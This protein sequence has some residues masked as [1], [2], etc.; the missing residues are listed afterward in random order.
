LED[1]LHYRIIGNTAQVLEISLEPDKTLI[2]D[3]GMLLY[4]DEE[5]TFVTRQD[6][7]TQELSANDSAESESDLDFDTPENDLEALDD[8]NFA[9]LQP[10]KVE[11]EEPQG[12]LLEKLWQ[13]TK[14][15][16]QE[17]GKKTG[18]KKAEDKV[19]EPLTAHSFGGIFDEPEGDFLPTE[20]EKE[21]EVFSWY[22]TH[23]TNESEYIRKIAFTT[24]N[25]G[26]VVPIDLSELAVPQ[27]IFQSGTF[28]CARKGTKLEKHLDTGLAVNFTKGKLFKLDR[29][30]G[31]GIVFIQAEGQ[32]IQRELENDA[33]RVSLFSLLAFEEG[34]ILDT[35]HIRTTD[36]MD[37]EDQTQFVLL[38]GTGKFWLQTANI[39]QLVYRLSPIIFDSG[40]SQASSSADMPLE[41]G[42]PSSSPFADL[43]ENKGDELLEG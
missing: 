43:E 4:V 25:S 41:D 40:D 9:A 20:P 5:V 26:I 21:E 36:S 11:P 8:F 27:L 29:L 17:I 16:F 31:E 24:S 35:Q 15:K 10:N 19:P 3:G 23:F 13:V 38:S 39:Q 6:D 18:E 28:L 22:L 12:T 30:S 34:L 42:Y 14:K 1:S 2:G 7:G 33:I 37:Y 32:V